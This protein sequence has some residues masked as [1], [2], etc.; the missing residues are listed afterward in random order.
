MDITTLPA[1]TD[2]AT[3]G[4]AVPMSVTVRSLAISLSLVERLGGSVTSE[5]RTAPGIGSCA[6]VADRDG[7]ELVL[8]ENAAAVPA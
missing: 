8:W 3:R 7:N 6:L 4:P 5:T 2:G 1:A